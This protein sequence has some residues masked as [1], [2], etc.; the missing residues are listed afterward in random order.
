MQK[1]FKQKSTSIHKI[2][3]YL[4][5]L[6]L[7]LQ[8]G[9]SLSIWA[10]DTNGPA[11]LKEIKFFVKEAGQDP[12]EITPGTDLAEVFP[13]DSLL[14]IEYIIDLPK[15]NDDANWVDLTLPLSDGLDLSSLNETYPD[16][17]NGYF[18]Y[19]VNSVAKTI[20]V[21]F[22][23]TKIVADNGTDGGL[24]IELNYSLDET[25]TTNTQEFS[26]PISSAETK[27]FTLRFH[28]KG[29]SDNMVKTGKF[30]DSNFADNYS[31]YM[32]DDL[33]INPHEIEWTIDVNKQLQLVPEADAFVI[34]TFDSTQLAY[35]P[36]SLKIYPLNI[37][38]NGEVEVDE[39][40][41][42]PLSDYE[43]QDPIGTLKI[44]IKKFSVIK[45]EN[46]LD[47]AYRIKYIT[48][49]KDNLLPST[50]R[51]VSNINVENKAEFNQ[52]KATKTLTIKHLAK[53]EAHKY[54]AHYNIGY[55]PRKFILRWTIDFNFSQHL[56][57]SF[58]DQIPAGLEHVNFALATG[59]NARKVLLSK[60]DP[61]ALEKI[62]SINLNNNSSNISGNYITDLTNEEFEE[63]FN[64]ELSGQTLKITPKK[65]T[66]GI[67]RLRFD[68]QVT[69][70]SH[71]FSANPVINT[72]KY[73]IT[74]PTEPNKVISSNPRTVNY[75]I[76]GTVSKAVDEVS[77]NDLTERGHHVNYN[78]NK[79]RWRIHVEP[80]AADM[81]NFVLEDT[82]PN[83]GLTLIDDDSFKVKKGNSFL[84]KDA[85]YTV[86]KNDNGF[87]LKFLNP[88]ND[89]LRIYYWTKFD[90]ATFDYTKTPQRFLNKFEG[91]WDGNSDKPKAEVGFTPNKYVFPNGG[92]DANPINPDRTIDWVI[93]TNYN[94]QEISDAVI[95][96]MIATGH[97][98]VE[99]S[100][101]V[102]EY[103]KDND[104]GN[105]STLN[106]LLN[107]TTFPRLDPDKYT[108]NVIDANKF[109]VAFKEN[110]N[111]PYAILYKTKLVETALS[112]ADYKNTASIPMTE[113]VVL[114]GSTNP[115]P[116]VKAQNVDK[117]VNFPKHD[118]F[119]VKNGVQQNV[120]VTER[121][122]FV[123]WTVTFN[124]SLSKIDNAVITD[125]LSAGQEYDLSSVE[126]YRLDNPEVGQ[127]KPKET[128][129]DSGYTVAVEQTT[130]GKQKMIINLG[131]I[132]QAYILKYSTV[133]P[134]KNVSQ[135][136]NTI[137]F[138]GNQLHSVT[139]PVTK[140]VNVL[141]PSTTAFSNKRPKA[142]WGSITIAKTNA[143]TNQPIAGI[144]FALYKDQPGTT[145]PY[146]IFADTDE[147]GIAKLTDI[148]PGKYIIKEV[149]HDGYFKAD[150]ISVEIKTGSLTT[151]N[152]KVEVK[153]NPKGSITI[154][155][156]E[157]AS[158][159]PIQDIEFELVA[160]DGT[161]VD[162]PKTDANGKAKLEDLAVGTYV[163]K[164][165]LS[166]K[167]LPIADQ[168]VE[169]NEHTLNLNLQ[170]ENTLH[171]PLPPYVPDTDKPKEDPKPETP[172]PDTPKPETPKP[173]TP[174]PETPGPET[175]KPETPK[176]RIPITTVDVPIVVVMEIPDG[177]VPQAGRDPK[178]GKITFDG[179]SYTYTPNKG[180]SG[181][182]DFSVVV[183]R[184]DGSTYEE[185][186]E[187]E[188]EIPQG[189][190]T[191]PKTDGFPPVLV[192]LLGSMLVVC[193]FMF[194]RKY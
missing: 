178:H 83:K 132:S 34:D 128:L 67:Y 108:I 1:L 159:K 189:V 46:Y 134:Q 78:E 171:D 126:I 18:T 167:Y 130:D 74:T 100:I 81:V 183:T 70:P 138:S 5:A 4:L 49:I 165:K 17:E 111:K 105:P 6:M 102:A 190:G 88:I 188:V 85:D 179:K 59:P 136:N 97:E 144:G 147:H 113:L 16:P 172:K 45:G 13:Q 44:S 3:A 95:T 63:N 41:P 25:S 2:F 27:T 122:W 129:V 153:N 52:V 33:S 38:L 184:P 58:E 31:D 157:K 176:P 135:V 123:D 57:Q 23:R 29:D 185:E 62:N 54:A 28:P 82:F 170:I 22:D 66:R 65:P 186:I 98:L 154:T 20:N 166:G 32:N 182:D 21:V 92:K 86:T 119:L 194:K 8:S 47:K 40:N 131:T 76:K 72:A 37:K 84:T 26:F 12:K 156:I 106:E 116:R 175:P 125:I 127:S 158:N 109:S 79:V 36:G 43:L 51:V 137:S 103:K 177:D 19:T 160:G 30:V 89:M 140:T 107:E 120:P 64:F 163:L 73:T 55:N 75:G 7:L 14:R 173:D 11:K 133:L 148:E 80:K 39:S 112:I 174:K 91:S 99:D 87:T 61:A 162:F 68:T 94:E 121:I 42:L 101:K 117:T 118:T 124:E 191:L 150:D 164:E 142:N 169:I 152:P 115:E 69:D 110:I 77:G 15:G 50:D 192:F 180:F 145:T 168:T 187:I 161:K 155:K 48:Y 56:L 104:T 53:P 35:K 151:L 71:D 143:L 93:Y 114:P 146:K 149:K 10:E 193:G 9:G 139:V 141:H 96:D 90:I 60:I 181:K 24:T